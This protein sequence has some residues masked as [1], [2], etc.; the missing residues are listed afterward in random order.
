MLQQPITPLII[1]LS[2]PVTEEISVADVLV[3][4]LSFTGW[5]VLVAVVLALLFAS[6]LIGLRRL[7]PSNP[8]NGDKTSRTSLNLHTPS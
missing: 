7:S 1:E 8:I 5:M 4:V 2:D 3:G 6:A